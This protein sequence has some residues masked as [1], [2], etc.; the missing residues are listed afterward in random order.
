MSLKRVWMILLAAAILTAA[1]AGCGKDAA[2]AKEPDIDLDDFMQD[3]LSRY[4][5]GSVEAVGDEM[6][7]AFYPGLRELNTVQR[8]VY[9]PRITGVV[10]EYAFLRCADAETAAKAAELLRQRVDAQSEGGAWYP[11]AMENWARARVLTKG[12]YVAM[13]AAGEET[14]AIAAD[15]EKLF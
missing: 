11:E 10:S 3:A 4:E 15:F 14:E 1:L 12:S 2:P 13:I 7:D 9:M 6:I 8:V 5:L